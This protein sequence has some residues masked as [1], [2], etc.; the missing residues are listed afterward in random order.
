MAFGRLETVYKAALVLELTDRSIPFRRE[1]PLPI[2]Y[3]GRRLPLG[4]RV[5]F[6][7]F[8]GV[9][10]EVKALPSI[11]P[12]EEAQALN[13]I[14]AAGQGRALVLNFGTTSLQ[15]RRLVYD[16]ARRRTGTIP[17]PVAF[18]RGDEES[19]PWGEEPG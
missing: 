5:D 3:K 9:L 12:I 1:V 13:Y 2:R 18:V 17:R 14:R 8:D 6:K 4:Y 10:V 19:R 16:T 11:G 7:C 15:Y